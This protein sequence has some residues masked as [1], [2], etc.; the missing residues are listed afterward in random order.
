MEKRSR[1][2]FRDLNHSG[3]GLKP[4]IKEGSR[5]GALTILKDVVENN[6][7]NK[8]NTHDT[9]RNKGKEIYVEQNPTDLEYINSGEANSINSK[10]IGSMRDSIYS[11]AEPKA[12]NEALNGLMFGPNMPNPNCNTQIPN[13]VIG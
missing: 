9:R 2:K 10:S 6:L 1:R 7:G 12:C 8:R 13:I 5:F 3:V 11:H 4:N